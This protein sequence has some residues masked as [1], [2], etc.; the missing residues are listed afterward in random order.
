M[1]SRRGFL[2]TISASAAG[3]AVLT[4]APISWASALLPS[5]GIRMNP[6]TKRL[7]KLI[8]DT[9]RERLQE[10]LVSEFRRDVP[11][12]ELLAAA[13]M[14][15][16]LR[17]GHHSVYLL[18]SAHQ[19]SLD[20]SADDRMLPLFWAVDVMKEHLTRFRKSAVGPLDGPLPSASEAETEFK[21]AMEEMDRE[22]AE[23]AIIAISRS[24]G[25]KQA[26][27]KFLPYACRDNFFIGHIPIGIVS[28]GRALETI[29]WHHAEPTLRY[30]VR[31]MYRQKHNLDGQPY[32]HNVERVNRTHTK[33][34][35]DWASREAD[36]EKTIEL[37]SVMKRGKWWNSNDWIA[38]RLIAG[39]IKA[40]TVWD[41][42]HLLAAEMMLLLKVGGR[43][44][45][46][47]PL[48]ANT[49]ANALHHV[50]STSLD[51]RTRYL[52]MLQ[53]LS[54]VTEFT[55]EAKS[56]D[57]IREGDIVTMQPIDLD[58]DSNDTIAE[59]LDALPPRVFLKEED[60]RTGQ[61]RAAELTFA[62]TQ[63][64]QGC[65]DFIAAAQHSMARRLSINAHEMKYPIAMFE[66]CRRVSPIWRPHLLAA[67]SVFLQGTNSE[68]N[69]AVERGAK[70]L[71]EG[72]SN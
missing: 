19:L 62:L 58:G 14:F 13:F 15:A 3:G 11:Y 59:L 28:A 49:A 17:D 31:D 35:I 23:R 9:S 69:P 12:R 10:L 42:I 20:L 54:W 60:D 40:G 44:L 8:D 34:P 24:Q 1:P 32:P 48:H 37:L 46:N 51:S 65:K 4:Q 72:V 6:E 56:R 68:N 16:A 50:F 29:G 18:H 5:V 64:Q 22:K 67:T 41:A 71:A 2:N 70:L 21:T 30:I 55:I 66:E 61:D 45:G 25:P 39:E 52:T 43:R 36:K 27:A 33:L 7:V 26:Y 57:G 63:S 38:E 53:A 47:R